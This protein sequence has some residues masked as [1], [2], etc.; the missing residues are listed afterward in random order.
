[1]YGDPYLP[2]YDSNKKKRKRRG[3][4]GKLCNLTA[5]LFLTTVC[6]FIGG[7]YFR[8][9]MQK[10]LVEVQ[11]LNS[12]LVSEIRAQ[13]KA[14]MEYNKLSRDTKEQV[15]SLETKSAEQAKLF[16]EIKSRETQLSEELKTAHDQYNL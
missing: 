13:N 2:Q 14:T 8:N 11:S 4:C 7:A 15:R 6:G 1:M 5:I 12:S 16:T 9:A 3:I 10:A